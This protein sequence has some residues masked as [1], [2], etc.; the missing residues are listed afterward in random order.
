[1][2][3]EFLIMEEYEE[4]EKYSWY[5]YQRILEDYIILERFVQESGNNR[6]GTWGISREEKWKLMNVITAYHLFTAV[7]MFT[8]GRNELI[9]DPDVL[10]DFELFSINF[11]LME[12]E[13]MIDGIDEENF[14]WQKVN[15][16]PL[17][18]LLQLNFEEEPLLAIMRI[19]RM[20]KEY[21]QEVGDDDY[22]PDYKTIST[23]LG[24]YVNQLL[25][26]LGMQSDYYERLYHALEHQGNLKIWIKK[27][28]LEQINNERDARNEYEDE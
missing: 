5:I 18:K 16:I 13:W 17:Y 27:H 14:F 1:M 4:Y 6:G 2:A 15:V 23:L 20:I 26:I 21:T 11:F 28:I 24:R 25:P 8:V 22:D 3:L 9:R 12:E 10:E 19:K 7:Y